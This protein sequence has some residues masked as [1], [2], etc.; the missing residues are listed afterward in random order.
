MI[1]L[2]A[3]TRNSAAN[4]VSALFFVYIVLIF[5]HILLS[6]LF[7]FGMRVPYARWTDAVIGFLR[8]VVEP[9][10]RVFRRFLPS[11]GAFDLSPLV[12]IIVLYIL[13]TIIVSLIR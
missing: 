2:A 11:M 6:M 10:L 12:G 9:Y 4:Y 8:D 13:R 7:S 5:V 3:I 1:A